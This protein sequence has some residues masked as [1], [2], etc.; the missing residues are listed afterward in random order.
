MQDFVLDNIKYLLGSEKLLFVK[1]NWI[2]VNGTNLVLDNLKSDGIDG[3]L[4]FNIGI[5]LTGSNTVLTIT[6]K[7]SLNEIVYQNINKVGQS[8]VAPFFYFVP[9]NSLNFDS[10]VSTT[11]GFNYVTIRK[12]S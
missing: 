9:G 8:I 7:K 10:T 4:I 1:T 2:W 5:T 6:N 3:I 12:A 11:Y